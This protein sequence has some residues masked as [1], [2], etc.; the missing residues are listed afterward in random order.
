MIIQ[1]AG[2]HTDPGE[3]RKQILYAILGVG[4]MA[5]FSRID[6]RDL[7]KFAPALYVV[8]VL[9]LAFILRGGHSSHGAQRCRSVA[10]RGM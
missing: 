5:A 10:S 9:L 1:S 8:I 6:Y 2:L 4:I 3:W 7:S